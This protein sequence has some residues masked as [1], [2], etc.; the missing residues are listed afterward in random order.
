[1][2][3]GILAGAGGAK[4]RINLDRIKHA[5]NLGYD[6]VWTAEAWGEMR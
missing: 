4:I 6:S 1:M 2:K 5:E 3:L